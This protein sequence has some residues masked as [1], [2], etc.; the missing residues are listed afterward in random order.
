MTNEDRPVDGVHRAP[1][2][3]VSGPLA[4]IRVAD[5]SRV[6]AG[7]HATMMLAD[8]GADVIKVE[9][10]EGDGTRQWSP[11]V[12]AIGQSTYFA[13]VN[14]GKR[15]VVCDLRTPEGREWALELART[16][17]VV[18]ENFKPGTMA[19]FGLDYE[20]LAAANPGVVYCSISGFGDAA[21]AALPGYDLL[22]QAVGGLMSITGEADGEPMKVGVALVDILTGL[23]AVI[24]IQAALRARDTAESPTSGAGQH[25]KVTLLGSLLSALANQASSTLETGESPSR[26]GNAH[27]SISPYETM[28]AKD[29]PLAVAVGT[30]AQFARLCEVLDI[31]ELARDERFVDNPSRV[32][33]RV[34]LRRLLE[35]RLASRTAA[36][37]TAAF[38]AVNIPA[39]RV[40]SIAQALELAES[41][42]LDIIAETPAK[43]PD[44]AERSVRTIA[45]PIAFSRTPA[46]YTSAP[47]HLGEHTDAQWRDASNP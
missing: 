13:G 21:G 44:G 40:N 1:D 47:P 29:Q 5:F 16:A 25:V 41:L 3:P 31:P 20:T 17:D 32:A 11:P 35:E 45:T 22:V 34:E 15:S 10:P 6:L 23:N 12:N 33:H 38:T 43:A 46:Q 27:P 9:S 18:I 14:R 28:Q 36:E 37:W 42:G 24:G 8:L 4:G 7:P 30:D 26:L 19:K 2:A 39:G